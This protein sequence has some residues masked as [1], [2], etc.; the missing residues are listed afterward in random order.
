MKR[1]NY[2]CDHCGNFVDVPYVVNIDLSDGFK[3][4]DFCKE[5]YEKFNNF[6]NAASKQNKEH[7]IKLGDE[8]YTNNYFYGYVTKII[9]DEIYILWCDGSAGKHNKKYIQ[10]NFTGVNNKHVVNLL[11]SIKINYLKEK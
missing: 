8:I 3:T 9:D 5:C 11:D 4:K 1:D 6:I 10:E 7:E 2:I